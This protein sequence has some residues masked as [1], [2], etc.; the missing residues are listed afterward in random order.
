MTAAI[1]LDV[2]KLE[3]QGSNVARVLL[4][5][6]FLLMLLEVFL[7]WRLGSARASTLN[8]TQ[9]PPT[10]RPVAVTLA[11]LLPTIGGLCLLGT[12]AHAMATDDFLGFLPSP[13]RHS[14]EL[15]LEVPQAAPGEGTRWRL[16]SLAYV[17]GS[18]KTDRW[19]VGAV[20][21]LSIAYVCFIYRRERLGYVVSAPRRFLRDARIAPAVLR[22]Q[23]M[24]ITLF[25]L[26]PQLQLLFEREAWPDIVI[27]FDDSKS[28]SVVEPFSAPCSAKKAMN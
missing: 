8:F 1:D 14:L 15:L 27:I 28:M 25:I 23:L 20:A 11:W 12:W 5:T 21:L 2:E 22:I 18:W 7:A 6:A 13:W 26:L 17:T 24:L 16:K 10:R 19:V 4:I 9:S 3:P